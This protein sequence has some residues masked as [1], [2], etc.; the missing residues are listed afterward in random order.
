MLSKGKAIIRAFIRDERGDI[1]QTGIIVGIF[2][3]LAVG[4]LMFLAPKIKAMFEKSG[5]ALDNGSGY[6]Y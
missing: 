2:A 5:A 6:S 3:V 4:G 1:L